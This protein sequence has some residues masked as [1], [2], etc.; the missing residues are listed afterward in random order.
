MQIGHHGEPLVNLIVNIR[1]SE[2]PSLGRNTDELIC[3]S[4]MQAEA[5]QQLETIV[6]RKEVERRAGD[7]LFMWGVGNSPAVITRSLARLGTPVR[8]VFSIMKTPPKA[9]DAKPSRTV[10]WRRYFASDGTERLL[11]PHVLVTSR[12]D[13]AGGAKRAHYALMCRSSHPLSI[14]RGETFDPNAFRNAGGT[15]APVGNSQVTALLKRIA[16][17][18][19]VTGYEVNLTA[20]LTDSY[21]VRLSDPV[22]LDALR[23]EMLADA[24]DG[25]VADWCETVAAIKAGV[26]TDVGLTSAVLI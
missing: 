22:E 12:G 14:K 6:H 15:G 16:P 11:P 7:G 5:G 20:W 24:A 26:R 10:A 8:A 25:S 21:W 13:S 19:A 23:L 17:D 3:W 18:A 1:G 4:R 9:I 2:T